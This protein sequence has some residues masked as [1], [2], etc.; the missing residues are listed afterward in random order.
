MEGMA[1][2]GTWSPSDA[3]KFASSA[4]GVARPRDASLVGK[5]PQGVRQSYAGGLRRRLEQGQLNLSVGIAP[6]GAAMDDGD[7]GVESASNLAPQAGESKRTFRTPDTNHGRTPPPDRAGIPWAKIMGLATP[8]VVTSGIVIYGILSLGYEWFYGRLGIDPAAVGLSYSTVLSR[9]TGFV[10]ISILVILIGLA[11]AIRD[12]PRMENRFIF[13]GSLVVSTL[14]FFLIIELTSSVSAANAVT[15]GRPIAPLSAIGITELDFHADP[16]RI[17]P[18]GKAG[19][20]PAVDR[21]V[22]RTDLL[23]LGQANGIVVLYDASTQSAL[24]IP[25]A[26]IVLVQRNCATKRPDPNCKRRFRPFYSHRS[27]GRLQEALAPQRPLPAWGGGRGRPPG[28]RR[29]AAGPEGGRRP[30]AGPAL[31]TWGRL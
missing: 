10:A 31:R 13:I 30:P 7:P 11:V 22:S 15:A 4:M 16:V 24:Y 28:D 8:I 9:S 18:V 23:Y 5:R 21:L 25:S 19:E 3:A 26:S 1:G 29:V 12:W 6:R 17:E 20:A 2:G 14:V 27:K